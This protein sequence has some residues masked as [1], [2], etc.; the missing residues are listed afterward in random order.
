MIARTVHNKTPEDQFNN[1]LF[2]SFEIPEKN[3]PEDAVIMDLD[4]LPVYI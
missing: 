1:P 4:A 3:I 2:A